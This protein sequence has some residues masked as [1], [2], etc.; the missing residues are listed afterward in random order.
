MW[1]VGALPT[2]PIPLP[3]YY[4]PPHTGVESGGAGMGSDRRPVSRHPIGDGHVVRPARVRRLFTSTRLRT[5]SG[6]CM[7][8]T[9]WYRRVEIPPPMP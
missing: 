1:S 9:R 5:R 2:L 7:S 8:D 6:A 3:S 4:A